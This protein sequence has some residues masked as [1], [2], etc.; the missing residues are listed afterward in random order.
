MTL[1]QSLLPEFDQEMGSTRQLLELVGKTDPAWKPHEKSW[2]LGDL[3]LHLANLVSWGETTL[4]TTELDLNPPGGPPWTP[5]VYESPE[6]T[7]KVFD[8]NV[9]KARAAIAAT[10]DAD[11]MVPWSL[12]N[13]GQAIFT[14][15]RVACL[16]FFVMNHLIHHR[17]QLTVY[18]RLKDV[19]LPSVY[20][21]TADAPM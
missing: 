12:K 6:A 9:A 14:M 10:S 13:A 5:P 16:R 7:L 15:P 1:A 20:G 2:S 3:S 18:L 21:P 8:A 4:Q 11:M 19:P 17:G